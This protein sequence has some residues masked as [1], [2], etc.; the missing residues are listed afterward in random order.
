M[1]EIYPV[2]ILHIPSAKTVLDFG[3][4]LVGR[5]RIRCLNKPSG[6]RVSFIH[7]EILEN[8]ELGVRPLRLAKCTDEVILLGVEL[9]AIHDTWIQI[10]P[11]GGMSPQ[12]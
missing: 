6:S 8:G 3:Q 7:A 1:E 10:H 11:D 12:G 5:L 9:C 2:E 4:N